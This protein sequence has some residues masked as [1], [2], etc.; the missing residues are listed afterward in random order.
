MSAGMIIHM[1]CAILHRNNKN[2]Q[3]TA[4]STWKREIA[5]LAGVQFSNNDF[6]D[7]QISKTIAAQGPS[8]KR[9]QDKALP[10]RTNLI[11]I[12]Q[13]APVTAIK[14]GMTF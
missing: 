13:T 3:I 7:Y 2:V 10:T 5:D 14:C 6:V 11:Q 12:K 1:V 4:I 9:R 8:Q